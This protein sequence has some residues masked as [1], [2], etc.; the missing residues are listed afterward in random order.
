MQK[1]TITLDESVYKGL[2]KEIG[3]GKISQFIEEL[4][5]PHVI[6]KNLDEEYKAMSEDTKRESE[7]QE[8]SE[9]LISDIADDSR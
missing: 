4:V 9:S 3:A 2:R 8:W 6:G 7:A 5:R 1:L